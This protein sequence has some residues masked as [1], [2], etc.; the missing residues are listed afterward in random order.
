MNPAHTPDVLNRYRL[1]HNDKDL[2]SV[3]RRLNKLPQLATPDENG[4]VPDAAV[5][6]SATEVAQLE[7]ETY[8]LGVER[9][10][11]SARTI[12]AQADSY[13]RTAEETGEWNRR[14]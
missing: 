2:R 1:I 13:L 4:Q 7:L 12:G 6:A 10:L 8:R 9:M 11:V 14:C 5:L 3:V